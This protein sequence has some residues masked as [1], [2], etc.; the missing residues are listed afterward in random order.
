MDETREHHSTIHRV[1]GGDIS[2][3]TTYY[4]SG[5]YVTICPH[6]DATTSDVSYITLDGGFKSASIHWGNATYRYDDVDAFWALSI[7]AATLSIGKTANAIKKTGNLVHTKE[8]A[9]V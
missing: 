8:H 4:E 3:G 9:T 7:F 1:A 5:H 6:D 2:V